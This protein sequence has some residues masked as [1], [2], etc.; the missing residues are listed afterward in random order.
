[1]EAFGQLLYNQPKISPCYSSHLIYT[2][3]TNINLPSS[4]KTIAGSGGLYLQDQMPN[5]NNSNNLAR[6]E[7]ADAKVGEDESW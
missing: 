1:L 7:L 2:N 6:I 5:N 3:Y 4:W